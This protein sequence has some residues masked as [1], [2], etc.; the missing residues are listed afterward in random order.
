MSISKPGLQFNELIWSRMDV[1]WCTEGTHP[2]EPVCPT[3]T[4]AATG[5]T[6]VDAEAPPAF[7]NAEGLRSKLGASFMMGSGCGPG[8]GGAGQGTGV[9]SGQLESLSRLNRRATLG[10]CAHG[11]SADYSRP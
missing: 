1:A 2:A 8:G 3:G 6:P 5:Q 11:L 10:G 7:P 4:G 9:G